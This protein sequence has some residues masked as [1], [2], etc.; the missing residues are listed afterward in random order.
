[1]KFNYSKLLGKIKECGLTQEK[2]AEAIDKD[3]STLNAK[4]NGKSA[5]TTNEIDDMCRVLDIDN[6]EIV[7]YFFA[8]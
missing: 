3:K 5:F 4:L 8:E 6:S 7:P 2:L 1:M